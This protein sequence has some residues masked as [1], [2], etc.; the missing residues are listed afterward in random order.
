MLQHAKPICQTKIEKFLPYN[1][2]RKKLGF[3]EIMSIIMS[4]PEFY[5]LYS[6]TYFQKNFFKVLG[7][8]FST[9]FSYNSYIVCCFKNFVLFNL[10]AVF[11]CGACLNVILLYETEKINYT[12]LGPPSAPWGPS[13][14]RSDDAEK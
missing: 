11:F 13:R 9:Q 14:F 5:F 3:E 4:W 2:L 8:Y 12:I 6:N 1:P 7:R 10:R